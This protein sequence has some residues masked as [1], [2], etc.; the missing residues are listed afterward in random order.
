VAEG[1]ES[2]VRIGRTTSG[3]DLSAALDSDAMAEH[4][5]PVGVG[6]GQLPA[7]LPWLSRFN[8]LQRNSVAAS[9]TANIDEMVRMIFP[10]SYDIEAYHDGHIN[11]HRFDLANTD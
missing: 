5:Q 1:N 3:L 7:G 4:F 11:R 10:H 6:D 9:S 8:I 2:D